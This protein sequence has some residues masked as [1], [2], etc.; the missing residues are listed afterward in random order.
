MNYI[1]IYYINV[2]RLTQLSSE[3]NTYQIYLNNFRQN[4]NF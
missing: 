1:K 4:Y 3:N 2:L